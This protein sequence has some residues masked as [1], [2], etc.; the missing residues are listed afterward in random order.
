MPWLGARAIS[1]HLHNRSRRVND[2]ARWTNADTRHHPIAQLHRGRCVLGVRRAADALH[3]APAAVT[4]HVRRLE[5]EFGCRLVV[6]QGRGITLSSDGGEL[7]IRARDIVQHRADAVHALAPL[8]DDEILVAA[9]EHAAEFL[10]P[11]VMALLYKRLPN[12][13][14]R[15]RSTR[16][17][18]VRD[19]VHDVRADIA[20]MLTRPVQ[21]A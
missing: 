10:V 14:I 21:A 15:L 16:S 19:L 6:P 7:A 2:Q 11:T 1:A 20:L 13:S 12:R 3:L 4:G 5:R 18:H 9:T 8:D 17:A